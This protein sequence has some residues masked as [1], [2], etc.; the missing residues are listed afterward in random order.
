MSS[1]PNLNEVWRPDNKEHAAALTKILQSKTAKDNVYKPEVLDAIENSIDAL[2][3]ELRALSVD[4]HEHPEL[5]FEEKYAHDVLTSFMSKKGF[6]VTPHFHLETAWSATYTRGSGG[7]TI[8]INSEMDALPGVGH[9]CGHNLIA[10][11]GVAVACAIKDAMEK[12]DLSGKIHLLGTPAEEGGAG[13]HKLLD[14]GA[15]SGMDVCLMCHPAPG[16]IGS[17]SLSSSLANK[18]V[19][20]EYSGHSAHAALSPWEGQNALDAAVMAYTNISVLRQQLKPTHRVHGIFS[21]QDW[22]VNIIPD[23]SK[24]TWVVRGPTVTEANETYA[25]VHRCFEA[26]ALATG[27]TMKVTPITAS[28]DIRQNVAL[29]DELAAIVNAR[30]GVIDYEWGIKSAST[31]FGRVGYEMPSLHPGF[32]IPTVKDGGNHTHAFTDAAV[33]ADSHEACLRVSKALA[34]V[35]MRALTDEDFVKKASFEDDKK[36]R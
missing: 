35:G 23:N 17:V 31:D 24:M 30:Y 25:R 16:P 27:C 34:G 33:T 6:S 8:G 13:K 20:V 2:S 5:R 19:F 15:Y 21:G 7:R 14:A 4:I 36:A 26:A 3:D 32:S 28:F 12:F 18:A 29:G 10:I 1:L 9:A 11:A 22:A